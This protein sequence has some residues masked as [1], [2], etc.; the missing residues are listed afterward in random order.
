MIDTL[1]N[2]P[3]YVGA[4]K[5][6][7]ATVLRH[8]AIAS[9][10]AN[11]E[12]PNYR[13]MDLAPSFQQELGRAIGTRDAAQITSLTPQLA[14]DTEAVAANSDGNTVRLEHELTQLSQNYVQHALENQLVTGSLLKLRMAI[15]GRSA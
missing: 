13:R 5:M 9:N 3:N 10:I 14:V 11:L 12:Q 7:E 1:F 15:T 2:Q 6:L 4:K 8:E